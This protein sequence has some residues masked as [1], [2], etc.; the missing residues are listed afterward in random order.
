METRTLELR[1]I[2]ELQRLVTVRVPNPKEN[3]TTQEVSTVM[4]TLIDKNP[5][6]SSAHQLVE[7]ASA[8][9]VSRA[10]EDIAVS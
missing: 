4:D 2:N 6:T 8:R 7:K 9:I 3:L 10:V 1:F 5:F